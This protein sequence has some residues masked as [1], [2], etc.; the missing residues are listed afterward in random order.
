MSQAIYLR[1]DE[2][3]STTLQQQIDEA[4]DD[5]SRQAA[6]DALAN[7]R[8]E[9]KK[10][11]YAIARG[12]I[13]YLTANLEIH[14]IE[15]TGNVTTKISGDSEENPDPPGPLAHVHEVQLAGHATETFIQSNDGTGHVR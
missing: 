1:M 12:T 10:L 15:T 7:A 8:I 6:E 9:W 4:A 5:A 3:L 2:V 11:A 14:G 13:E